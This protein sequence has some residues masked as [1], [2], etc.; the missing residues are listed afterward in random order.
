MPRAAAAAAVVGDKIVVV[1][2]QA[3]GKLVPQTEVYE[4]GEG[5]TDVDEIPT[6]P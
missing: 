1:G 5:W 2:G 3:D 6:P 4:D